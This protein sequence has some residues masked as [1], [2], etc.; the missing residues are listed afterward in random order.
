MVD[1]AWEGKEG[2]AAERVRCRFPQQPLFHFF[3]MYY[4]S[5]MHNTN[6]S[7]EI[8]NSDCVMLQRTGKEIPRTIMYVERSNN[9]S[10][11]SGTVYVRRQEMRYLEIIFT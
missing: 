2:T 8:G 7:V 4:K 10:K 3:S 5:V 11:K 6:K 1:L 9:N